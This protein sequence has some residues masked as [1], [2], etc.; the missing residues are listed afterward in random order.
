M[1]EEMENQ[2]IELI[3]KQEYDKAYDLIEDYFEEF[4]DTEFYYFSFSDVLISTEQYEETIDLMLEALNA[5]YE[6]EF[7]Y[8]RLGDAYYGLE[9]YNKALEWYQ[10]TNLNI[11]D[12]GMM[13]LI[14]MIGMCNYYLENY[15]E[16]V[17]YFEDV[18]LEE[19]SDE[20]YYN[21][22]LA[23]LMI[24]KTK[25]AVEY[26]EKVFQ[27]KNIQLPICHALC[28]VGAFEEAS[29]FFSRLSKTVQ[30]HFDEWEAEYYEIEENYDIA[31]E[32]MTRAIEKHPADR[33]KLQLALWL[34]DHKSKKEARK[35][36][37]EI[38]DNDVIRDD[39]VSDY[40]SSHLDTLEFLKLSDN[41]QMKYLSKWEEHAHND[42][43]IYSLFLHY[44]IKNCL[45]DY[46][47]Y[48]IYDFMLDENIDFSIQTYLE[49][50]KISIHL[51]HDRFEEALELLENSYV[52]K[53]DLYY[54]QLMMCLYHLQR[55]QDVV[56]LYDY[57]MP[58]GKAALVL[59]DCFVQLQ[60]FEGFNRVLDEMYYADVDSIED[61]DLF[62]EAL[63]SLYKDAKDQFLDE[64]K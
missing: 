32:S 8:E 7:L 38:I 19:E 22:A 12:P 45:M 4:G 10:K 40:I 16:A 31:I 42:P 46:Q 17:H 3:E 50:L 5:G 44:A 64:S 54:R 1:L 24:K 52:V 11:D 33:L 47:D 58:G 55:Y 26:F 57:I 51:N 6:N 20:L 36:M 18:L 53:N 37:K 2:I 56:D 34:Y 25:R 49:S 28:L 43:Y 60:D 15:E 61:I 41:T 27:D 9:E 35:I 14:Y 21:C 48:L 39:L 63:D 13:H 30:Y 62:Y 59:L 29:M 23:Y